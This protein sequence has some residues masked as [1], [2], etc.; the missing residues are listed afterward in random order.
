MAEDTPEVIDLTGLTDSE[1]EEEEEE[2]EDAEEEEH[3][4]EESVQGSSEDE[5]EVVLNET[6]RE[7]LQEAIGKLGQDRMRRVLTDLVDSIPEVEETLIRQLL[8][9]KRKTRDIV[10]RWERCSNCNEEFDVAAH[11]EEDE[12]TPS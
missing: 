10:C 4:E 8:T 12:C 5:G 9:L 6:T 11:R 3:E 7:R 1:S 2:E